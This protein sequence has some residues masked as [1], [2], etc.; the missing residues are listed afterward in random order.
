MPQADHANRSVH[1]QPGA[2]NSIALFHLRAVLPGEKSLPVL[3]HF[4][5]R[6]HDLGGMDANL[7]CLT[8]GLL[9]CHPLHED[10]KLLAVAAHHLALA[11]VVAPPKDHHLVVLSD[12]DGTHIVL[13][14]EFLAQRAAHDLSSN[15]RRRSEMLLAIAPPGHID[16]CLLLHGECW[17]PSMLA[18][19]P[20]LDG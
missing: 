20:G 9:A 3:V 7:N 18:A 4:D 16:A 11:V 8:I 12:R 13:R 14:L 1:I 15:V 10:A 2:H 5:L 19:L 6:D 17:G